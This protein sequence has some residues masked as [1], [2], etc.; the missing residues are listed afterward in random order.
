MLTH[1]SDRLRPGMEGIAKVDT[2]RRKLFWIW[3][4]K[5]VDWLRLT[6]WTWL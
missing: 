5:F 4:H 1:N 6:L 3:T 2:G